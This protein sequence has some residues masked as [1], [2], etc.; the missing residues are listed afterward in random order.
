MAAGSIGASGV[1]TEKAS[2]GSVNALGSGNHCLRSNQGSS[3]YV[4]VSKE[5]LGRYGH[6]EWGG[7]FGGIGAADKSVDRLCDQQQAAY[8]AVEGGES[9]HFVK[10]MDGWLRR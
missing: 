6:D 4:V 10:R 8:D 7:I 1:D 2:V 9:A 5:S 3:T